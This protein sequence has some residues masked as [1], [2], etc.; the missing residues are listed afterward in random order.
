MSGLNGAPGSAIPTGIRVR[1][2]H[3]S[4][5]AVADLVGADILHIKGPGLAPERNPGRAVSTDADVLVRPAHVRRLVDGLVEHGWRLWCDFDEGSAFEH[6]ASF[7]HRS[8]GMLDIHQNFPGLHRDPTRS[9][10]ALWVDREVRL[11]AERPCAAP[12]PIGEHLV[13]LLHAARTPGK[14]LDV[15]NH[16]HRLPAST[17][18]QVRRAAADLGASVGLAI[19]LREVD[20]DEPTSDPEVLLW[21]AM[22]HESDR[23]GT[24]R[25]RW[26]LTRGMGARLRLLRRAGRVN[27][28]VLGQRLGRPPTRADVRRE[29]WRRAGSGITSVLT[30][31]GRGR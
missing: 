18:H 17:R 26:A 14:G 9:F 2:A 13:L 11:I 24:W 28:F 23:L 1:F 22:L 4:V 30:G 19:A 15:E 20:V 10:E 12:G 21:R 8:F 29:W 3:A 7:H 16:W 25:A 5:Q 6:A 27:R 31:R